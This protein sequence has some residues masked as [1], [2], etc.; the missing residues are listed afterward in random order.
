MTNYGPNQIL[1][2]NTPLEGHLSENHE[3][4]I[5]ITYLRMTAEMLLYQFTNMFSNQLLV[6]IVGEPII[7]DTEALVPPD[8]HHA[9]R[10]PVMVG[11]CLGEPVVDS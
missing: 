6:L 1:D 2:L 3:K 11:Q 5:K 8:P 4:S 9:I 10:C 7:E